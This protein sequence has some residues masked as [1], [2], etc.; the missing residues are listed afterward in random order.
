MPGARRRKKIGK[1]TRD[2]GRNY[3]LPRVGGKRKI[4]EQLA[5][6]NADVGYRYNGFGS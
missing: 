1:S 3:V 5:G 2:S 4:I 6:S